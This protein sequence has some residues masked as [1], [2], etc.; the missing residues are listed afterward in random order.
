MA[1]RSSADVVVVGGGVIGCMTAYELSRANLRVTLLDRGRL[2]AEA[3]SASA[4]ILVP[5]HLAE[6]DTDDPVFKF[7]RASTYLFDALAPELEAE[8]GVR[9]GYVRSGI[10][11]IAQSDDEQELLEENF[12]VWQRDAGMPVSWLDV[13]ELHRLEPGF[14]PDVLGGIYSPDER[15]ISS[16]R[17]V[18][19]LGRILRARDVDVREGVPATGVRHADRRVQAVETPQGAISTPEVVLTAG[20]WSGLYG[21]WFDLNLPIQPMRGQMVAVRPRAAVLGIPAVTYNGAIL[22][23]PDGTVHLG[24]TVED[25]GFDDRTTVEGIRGILEAAPRVAPALADATLVRAWS[26]LRPW[27]A[28]GVPVIGRVPGWTGATI[29][30]GHFKYGVSG[31]PGTGRAVR[32]LIVDGRSDAVPDVMSPGRFA[33]T[34]PVD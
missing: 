14:G 11:R 17:F 15:T 32:E 9:L 7:Q 4:G 29:A 33:E 23:K 2:G 30:S 10:L 26:G 25:V 8:S 28:D 6:D 21:H 24:S 16:E 18:E 34:Q 1:T 27:S 19:S 22:P 20:A 5:L 31:S 3:S 13:D 12:Q